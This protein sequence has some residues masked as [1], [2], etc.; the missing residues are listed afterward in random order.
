[1][2]RGSLWLHLAVLL[3]LT[4]A[5]AQESRGRA[6]ICLA[7]ASV[8]GA[9]GSVA[10]VMTAVRETFTSYL[11]GPS[12]EVTP[13]KAR[14]ESQAREEARGA[15]CPYLLL[16]KLKHVRKS[17]GG[18]LRRMAGSAV[19]EGAWSAGAAATSTVGRVASSAAAGAA[20]AAAYDFAA[21]IRTKDELTLTYRLEAAV[22][23]A[24][25]K[26][27]EKRKAK[28]DGEDLLTP[29]VEHAANAVVTAVA[30]GDR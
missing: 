25:V 26:E 8:E 28:F 20:G 18:L 5:A 27:S 30:K 11:T 10:E 15:R 23:T 13:L 17:G 29:L 24:L 21:A 9:V 22:G 16:V 4:A 6:R 19:Q 7:P 14:L 3:P 12:V 2:I 1:M